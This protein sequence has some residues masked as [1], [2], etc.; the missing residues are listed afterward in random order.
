MTVDT[1][2]P[3]GRVESIRCEYKPSACIWIKGERNHVQRVLTKVMDD[4]SASSTSLASSVSALVLGHIWMCCLTLRAGMR[5][6]ARVQ[7]I[8]RGQ[9]RDRCENRLSDKNPHHNP[10][11]SMPPSLCDSGHFTLWECVHVPEGVCLSVYSVSQRLGR[12]Q[13]TPGLMLHWTKKGRDNETAGRTPTCV[14][15]SMRVHIHAGMW[16]H[17]STSTCGHVRASMFG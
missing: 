12:V 10:L 1:T 7:S 6:Q 13:A 16:L 14:F 5:G 3:A 9:N 4:P 15:V 11:M 8:G 17:A 2:Q